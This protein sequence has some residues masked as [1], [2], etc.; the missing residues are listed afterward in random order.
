[1]PLIVEA[2]VSLAHTAGFITDPRKIIGFPF[3]VVEMAITFSQQ[4]LKL[5]VHG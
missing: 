2:A 5:V 4:I 3:A 1:M